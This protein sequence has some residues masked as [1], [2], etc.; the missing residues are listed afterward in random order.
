MQPS[1]DA[2]SAARFEP[3]LRLNS[4]SHGINDYLTIDQILTSVHTKDGNFL[5]AP[6]RCL[7]ECPSW[8]SRKNLGLRILHAWSKGSLWPT[9]GVP[10]GLTLF[11]PLLEI[12]RSIAHFLE[13]VIK[14][15]I[16]DLL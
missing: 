3:D 8:T 16:F 15:I 13:K 6:R 7:I 10:V 1:S 14:N 11:I 5:E 12:K 9:K 2:L 4:N